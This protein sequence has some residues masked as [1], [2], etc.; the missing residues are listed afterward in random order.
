MQTSFLFSFKAS[1]VAL[2]AGVKPTIS[3]RLVS[4][5]KWSDKMCSTE[6]FVIEKADGVRQYSQMCP[7]LWATEV[8]ILFDMDSAIV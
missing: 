3:R 1:T 4:Q 6:N 7:A 2:P 8:L 5:Q